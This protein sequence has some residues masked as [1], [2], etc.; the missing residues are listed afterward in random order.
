MTLSVDLFSFFFLM[1]RRP[2]R[3]TLFPYTTLFRSGPGRFERTAHAAPDVELVGQIERDQPVVD[4]DALCHLPAGD[5]ALA[6]PRGAE[7]C[8]ARVGGDGREEKAGRDASE[9]AGLVDARHR[10]AKGLVRCSRGRDEPIELGVAIEL[11]PLSRDVRSRLAVC[12]RFEVSRLLDRRPRVV[13][14]H[15][16]AAG[17]DTYRPQPGEDGARPAEIPPGWHSR[18]SPRTSSWIRPA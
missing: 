6:V 8:E 13:R 12:L 15:H 18:V 11:P 14:S 1:I 4:R 7:V 17:H 2:P 10:L 5:G 16:A 9:R 3:S